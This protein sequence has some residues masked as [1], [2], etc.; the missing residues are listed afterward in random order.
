[1]KNTNVLYAHEVSFKGF[2]QLEV[3]IDPE[4]KAVW[5]YFNAEPRSCFTLTLL[6]E[7]DRFQEM[8]K[9]REGRLPWNGELVDIEY[10]VIT[11]RHSVFSFGGDLDYFIQCIEKNDRQSLKQYAKAC[12]DAIYY[13]HIGREVGLTT[14]SLVHGNALGGGFEAALSSNVIVAERSAEMGLPEILFNLF[15]GMGAFNLLSQRVSAK[16]AEKMMLSG[17]LYTAEEMYYKGIVDHLVEDGLG[18]ETIN[19]I[20][21]GNAKHKNAIDAIRHVRQMSN[22]IDYD[23][24][25]EIADLWVESAFRLSDKDK[26]VMK[27][28]VN[29][30]VRFAENTNPPA[31]SALRVAQ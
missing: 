8:I 16:E 26:R 27:R 30:Q 12:I 15:P 17:R 23:L 18:R 9:Q 19:S 4:H 7:L 24:L 2:E 21:R 22:P 3:E 13:H 5:L 31:A 14:I 25:M 29:S 10:N 28:L 6:N 11:S 20:I 1:M